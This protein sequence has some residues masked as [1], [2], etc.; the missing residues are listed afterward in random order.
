MVIICAFAPFS[1]PPATVMCDIPS[2]DVAA[3]ATTACVADREEAILPFSLFLLRLLGFHV[4]HAAD[5][6]VARLS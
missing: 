1:L 5:P 2:R 3:A 6:C 4:A